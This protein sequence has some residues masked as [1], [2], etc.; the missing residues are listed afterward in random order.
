LCYN[1]I[2]FQELPEKKH[3]EKKL[4]TDWQ[5]DTMTNPQTVTTTDNKGRYN[6]REPTINTFRPGKDMII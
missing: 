2:L 3:F 4:R 1:V 5:R 6:A